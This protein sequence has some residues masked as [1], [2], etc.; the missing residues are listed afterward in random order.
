MDTKTSK[1]QVGD[2]VRVT[3]RQNFGR[4]E[5][6]HVGTVTEVYGS[7][8]TYR[9]DGGVACLYGDDELEAV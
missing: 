1:F 3:G 4:L 9:L 6:G 7:K 8:P 5:V 2:R